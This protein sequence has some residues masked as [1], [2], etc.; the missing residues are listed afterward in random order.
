MTAESLGVHA[1]WWKGP[2][3]LQQNSRFWPAKEGDS[4]RRNNEV[5][6]E[7]RKRTTQLLT[8]TTYATPVLQAE[9]FS[10]YTRLI[11]V[12]VWVLRFVRNCRQRSEGVL[13]Y[14]TVFEIQESR[15]TWIRHAQCND[16]EHEIG[17]IS[18]G[19]SLPADSAV[20][21][22]QPFLDE[23]GLLSVKGRLQFLKVSQEDNAPDPSYERSRDIQTYS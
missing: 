1:V 19:Q 9:M 8:G 4:A 10:S 21:Q 5:D 18:R 3:W 16:Y 22:F 11:R 6:D 15:N 13:M 23:Q 17:A 2:S 7:K 20:V 14:L 12:T